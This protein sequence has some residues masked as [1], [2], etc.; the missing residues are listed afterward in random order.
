MLNMWRVG[1][2]SS[3]A[4]RKTRWGVVLGQPVGDA[5]TPVV[6]P[7]EERVEPQV[8]HGVH[9]VLRLSPLGVVEVVGAALGLAAVAVAAQVRRDHREI[10][11]QP[12][13]NLVPHG[14]RLRVTVQQQ[15]RG[16]AA[17]FTK[18]TISPLPAVTCI[19]SN[20]S[21]RGMVVGLLRFAGSGGI[22]A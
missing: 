11:R 18:L 7:Q 1:T 5:G 10:L 13:R 14:M 8:A 6:A 4:S 2:M 22:V 17:P 21:N 9:Q 12:R 16:A 15:E 20:P 19:R 3:V